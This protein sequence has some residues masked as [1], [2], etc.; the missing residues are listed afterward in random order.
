MFVDIHFAF[1]P[2]IFTKGKWKVP[3]NYLFLSVFFSQLRLRFLLLL[4]ELFQ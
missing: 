1:L 4:L 3:P 2:L